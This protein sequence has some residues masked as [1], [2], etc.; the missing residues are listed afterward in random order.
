M[1]EFLFLRLPVLSDRFGVRHP[2]LLLGD[3]SRHQLDEASG[4]CFRKRRSPGSIVVIWPP[5]RR[6]HENGIRNGVRSPRKKSQLSRVLPGE[7]TRERTPR[8]AAA[9]SAASWPGREGAM[10][11]AAAYEGAVKKEPPRIGAVSS[12]SASLFLPSLR[13]TF[14]FL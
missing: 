3:N 12:A 2:L 4:R 6:R 8:S 14:L 9:F 5:D 1:F 13:R 10:G 11:P 7:P